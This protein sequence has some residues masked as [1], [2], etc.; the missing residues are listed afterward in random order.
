MILVKRSLKARVEG[1]GRLGGLG[2][3]DL[4]FG[5]LGVQGLRGLGIEGFRGCGR[6]G[7]PLRPK[8][9]LSGPYRHMEL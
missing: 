6:G 5:G 7:L 1:L 4:G 2:L 9:R 3:R 8:Y